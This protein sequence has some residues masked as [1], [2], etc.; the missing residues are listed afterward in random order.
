MF[1]RAA[2]CDV[3]PRDRPVRLAGYA[4]RQ[5]PVSIILDPIE[6]AALLL[7]GDGRRCLILG[8]DLMIVGA[9]LAGMIQSRLDK[10]GFRP[11]EVMM[12]ASHTHC[13]PATD[14]ACAR[15]GTPDIQ[16]IDDAAEAAESL[17]RRILR[18]QPREVSLDIFRGNLDHAVNRR[19][20]WPLPTWDRTQGL[21]WASVT[22]SPYPAGPRDEQATVILIRRSDDRAPL[23]AFSHYACHPT[24]MVPRDVI[25]ADYPGAIRGLLRERFGE[26]P[27]LFAPG[28]C[29][30]ITPRL[31][32]TIQR[33]SPRERFRKLLRMVVAGYMVQA[34]SSAD[35]LAWRRSLVARLGAILADGPMITLRPDRLRTGSSSIP[36]SAFFSGN[37]PD[38]ELML[39]IVR[40]DDTLEIFALSAEPTVEWQRILDDTAP[41]SSQEIRLYTGYLGAVFGYLPTAK[42]VTEGGYEVNGFQSLFGMSGRFDSNRILPAVAGCVRSALETLEHATDAA[43]SRAGSSTGPG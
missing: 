8:F 12:L 3:T 1:A 7:E 19:R 37:A 27:C 31:V 34:V 17:V 6:I 29:G 24:S 43:V 25:S 18:D 33:Q 5:T 39:Q 4:S 28:F 35:S 20:R 40:L 13:A 9:E 15:L 21:Q 36:L 32:P 2:Y 38:K 26:I 42:Q 11:D 30:D 22:F 16:F 14:S 41:R 23:A 10:L